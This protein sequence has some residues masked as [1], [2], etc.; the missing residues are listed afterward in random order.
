M[1]FQAEARGDS[2]A[3]EIIE[4][5][6]RKIG[7]SLS[8]MVDLLDLEMIILGGS[9]WKGSPEFISRVDQIVRKFVMTVEAKRD[10]KIVSESFEN[11][12]LIGAAADVFINTGLL[13]LER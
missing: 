11:S 2:T 8:S 4:E 9:V 10:L 13:K 12:A 6:V 5:V 1:V 7:I 3:K